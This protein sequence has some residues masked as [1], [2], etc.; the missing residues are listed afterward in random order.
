MMR[1]EVRKMAEYSYDIVIIGAGPA[2]MGCAIPLVK[3]RASVCVIDRA[4]FPRNKTCAG[5]VTG[6]TYRLIEAIF[7]GKVSDGLFC[8]TSGAVKLFKKTELLVEAG[9]RHSV[10]LVNRREFDNALVEEYKHLGG[11]IYEGESGIRIDYDHNCVTLKNGDTIRYHYILFADGAL[12]MAHHLL[13]TDKRNL[14][15]G[16]E[17]YIPAEKL[18]TDSVDLYFGYLDTG[19][20]WVFPHGDTVCVGLADLYDR[21]TDYRGLIERFVSDLGIDPKECDYIG[22][23]LPYG[24]VIPQEK[25]GDN[26]LLLGD[27]G[28]FTD[29]ISGEGLYMA[30]QSGAYA[31]KALI[32]SAH[33]KKA[34][35]DSM[36]AIIRTVKDGKKV[37]KTFYS[38]P[39]HKLFLKKVVGKSKLVSFFFE[40]MVEDYR[41]EY[42]DIRRL[43]TDYKNSEKE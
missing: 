15:F 30:L 10:R 8:F 22:A 6:K 11:V 34:Y 21:K 16:M 1:T 26:I 38:S 12:S 9:L 4:T 23:Y 33:P 43:Y 32:G 19:Y 7:D 40:E 20:A 37:Q 31:A 2:G 29:P 3:E 14:A 24:T 5:L 35:L 36:S 13:K 17:A 25:L 28:G 41:C 42:R 27:A 18:Y 39:I